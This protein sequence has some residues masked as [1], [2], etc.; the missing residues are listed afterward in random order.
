MYNQTQVY[1]KNYQNKKNPNVV[2]QV[3]IMQ[4]LTRFLP[5]KIFRFAYTLPS[6][7]RAEY[8]VHLTTADTPLAFFPTSFTSHML[9]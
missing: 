3:G 7:F 5:F 6:K 8:L 9:A 4:H 1:S 2:K